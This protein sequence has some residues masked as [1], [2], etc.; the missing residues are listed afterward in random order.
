MSKLFFFIITA[1][2]F[3]NSCNTKPD[4][5]SMEKWKQEIRQTELDFAKMA[6]E[7]GIEKAFIT[8]AAE[9]AVVMRNNELVKG[10]K[11]IE[12]FYKDKTSKGL[13]WVPDFVDV[14][15]SGDLGY[16]YGHYT[17]SYIDST[18]KAAENKGIFHTVWKKQSDG[19]WRFV[20]D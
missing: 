11:N 3:L 9:D 19:T 15:A 13:D 10:L 18:G 20:W 12:V 2:L 16:T 7:E 4:I 1:S 17:Y 5:K 14:S 6:K 8:Y